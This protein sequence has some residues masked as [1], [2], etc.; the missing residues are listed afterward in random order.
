MYKPPESAF[1][2]WFNYHSI[3]FPYLLADLYLDVKAATK[4]YTAIVQAIWARSKCELNFDPLAAFERVLFTILEVMEDYALYKEE[5][6]RCYTT[7]E[8]LLLF[9]IGACVSMPFLISIKAL[10][11]S[12]PGLVIDPI[13]KNDQVSHLTAVNGSLI[14]LVGAVDFGFSMPSLVRD[15]VGKWI[16]SGKVMEYWYPA[17]AT[18]LTNLSTPFI[19]SASLL[20]TNM[21]QVS[22]ANNPG[23]PV[24]VE[25]G[26]CWPY[27]SQIQ[28]GGCDNI[29]CYLKWELIGG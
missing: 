27:Y 14:D 6:L 11:Q 12:C 1:A 8:L 3:W 16:M 7:F 25:N 19:L 5:A 29:I 28:C 24:M 13:S 4:H 9:A 23:P 22:Y 15:Q 21:V 26:K 2:R 10:E 17:C 20:H 18:V